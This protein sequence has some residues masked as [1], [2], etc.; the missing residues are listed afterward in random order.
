MV[1]IVR[2]YLLPEEGITLNHYVKCM[3]TF[4]FINASLSTLSLVQKQFDSLYDSAWSSLRSA[5]TWTKYPSV[6][7]I[8][9]ES[10]LLRVFAALVPLMGSPFS[11]V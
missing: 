4:R 2:I 11:W 10:R 3:G 5:C 7:A 6:S 9:W 1:F 8:V